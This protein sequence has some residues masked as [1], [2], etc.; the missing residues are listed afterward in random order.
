MQRAFAERDLHDRLVFI[1]S[2][3]LGFPD[4]ALLAFTLGCDLVNVGR[5]ALLALGCVQALRC[6]TNHCPT[7]IATQNRW[8]ARGVDS[9]LKSVRLANYVT[10]LRK[11]LLA[12]SRACGAP[13]P[14]QVHPR[15]L[16]ILDDR[17]GSA[18]VA[19]LFGGR[20]QGLPCPDEQDA[21]GGGSERAARSRSIRAVS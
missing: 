2:A 11:E 12:L 15:L 6:H 16:E 10:T 13:H 7:G 5:E 4:A 20:G 1:G 19:T 18:T 17:F 14:S 9:T 21:V 3:K 8:L